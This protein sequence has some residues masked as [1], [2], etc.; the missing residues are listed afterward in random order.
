MALNKFDALI[1]RHLLSL[2]ALLKCGLN[3]REFH[4]EVLLGVRDLML[5]E[6]FNLLHFRENL[7]LVAHCLIVLVLDVQV[8]LLLSLIVVLQ[9]LIYFPQILHDYL[10]VFQIRLN[11]LL[12]HLG[13]GQLIF[14][15]L[16]ISYQLFFH[17][18]QSL[19]VFL[20]LLIVYTSYVVP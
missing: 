3:L 6:C 18:L 10:V 16:L 14:V 17:F 13:C 4:S 1:T 11:L 19:F 9:S 5:K 15:V 12:F 7:L 8:F 20:H 2:Q